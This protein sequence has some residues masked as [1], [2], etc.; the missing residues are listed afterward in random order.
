MGKRGAKASA[1]DACGSTKRV[2]NQAGRRE[3]SEAK[4]DQFMKDFIYGKLDNHLVQTTRVDGNLL[5]EAVKKR[6]ESNDSQ[7]PLTAKY[8][9]ELLAVYG[10]KP[11]LFEG[12]ELPMDEPMSD[13]LFD[14]L[15]VATAKKNSTRCV[16]DLVAYF[17]YSAKVSRTEL[18]G[19]IQTVYSSKVMSKANKDTVWMAMMSHLSSHGVLDD[20]EYM[21]IT[22]AARSCFDGSL[23]SDWCRFSARAWTWDAWLARK[24]EVAYFVLKKIDVDSVLASLGNLEQVARQIQRLHSSGGLLADA[25][26][27]EP[28]DKMASV[29]FASSVNDLLQDVIDNDFSDSSIQKM[30]ENTDGKLATMSTKKVTQRRYVEIKLAGITSKVPVGST[31]FERDMHLQVALRQA[32]LGKEDGIPLLPHE[33]A[34]CPHLLQGAGKYTG[35]PKLISG[36]G[37]FRNMFKADVKKKNAFTLEKQLD[38]LRL[39]WD[40]YVGCNR[41]IVIEKAIMEQA[42]SLIDAKI[43]AE[44]LGVLPDEGTRRTTPEQC[45]M[46]IQALCKQERYKVTSENLQQ[47]VKLVNDNLQLMR[48]GASPSTD[49]AKGASFTKEAYQQFQH[50]VKHEISASATEKAETL[51]GMKAFTFKFNAMKDCM[52]ALDAIPKS[53]DPTVDD[54]QVLAEND[55]MMSPSMTKQTE[56]WMKTLVIRS[57]K[58]LEGS[59][60]ETVGAASSSKS[61]TLG[62]ASSSSS[63]VRIGAKS[64][65]LQF[66]KPRTAASQ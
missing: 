14:A 49:L 12:L 20:P 24:R 18:V 63:M 57:T 52:D 28:R 16:D 22:Q 60:K 8:A 2:R 46:A 44:V 51:S 34:L 9:Q 39:N 38:L 17:Q 43:S 21:A 45:S 55:F 41:Y 15:D 54:L 66:F 25:L 11:D 47:Q 48:I 7:R 32:S 3:P 62:A 10:A 6:I 4:A 64:Q 35:P 30:I 56:E 61:K 33:E 26:F 27:R 29:A 37:D 36:I 31:A 13:K 53:G 59:P 65:N 19:S 5:M 1:P 50:F 58:G 23:Y 42:Q 40:S